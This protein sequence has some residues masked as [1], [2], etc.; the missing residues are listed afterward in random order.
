[1]KPDP[2]NKKEDQVDR[3]TGDLDYCPRCGQPID[4]II[5]GLTDC[6]RCGLHFECC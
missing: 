1:M 2:E 3:K 4:E 5:W 6:P